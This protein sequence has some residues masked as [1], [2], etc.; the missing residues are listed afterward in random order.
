MPIIGIVGGI[1][2]LTWLFI[3]AGTVDPQS[4]LE[5]TQELG[6]LRQADI[7]LNSVV[8]AS[9]YGLIPD[10]DPLVTQLDAIDRSIG[11]ILHP[12][13]F[14]PAGYRDQVALRARELKGLYRRKADMIDRFKRENSVLRNSLDYFP[15]IADTYLSNHQLPK[16]QDVDH[17]IHRLLAYIRNSDPGLLQQLNQTQKELAAW[18]P[19]APNSAVLQNLLLHSQIIL[20]RYPLVDEVTRDILKLPTIKGQETL[21]RI[22]ATGHAEAQTAAGHFRTVLYIFA[23]FLVGYL[24]LLFFRLESARRAL[25]GIRTDLEQQL[26]AQKRVED[27]LR[28]YATVFTNAAEGMV[29]TDD[30]NRIV[31]VNPAFCAIT[32]FQLEEV[33]GKTPALLRSGRHKEDFYQQ[34]WE[35]LRTTN[36]WR[37]EIWNRR[38]TGELFPEWLSI[39]AV[40]DDTGSPRN[41]LAIFSDITEHKEAEAKIHHLA[42]HDALTG[43]PNRMLLEDRLDQAILQVKRGHRRTAVMYLDLDRFKNINDSLGHDIGDNLLIQVASRCSKTLRETDTICRQ[44]GDEFVI[45]LPDLE[46]EQDAAHIARKLVR[47]FDH[48]FPL[49]GHE[50]RVTAS[51]GIAIYPRDG[52][53]TSELLRNADTAM[54]RAKAEG[55][56]GFC[57]YS[58]DMNAVS[59]SDLLLESQLRRAIDRDELL[60]EFQPKIHAATGAPAGLEAL[61]RW[62]HPDQGLIP[63]SRFIPVAEESGLIGSIGEWVLHTACGQIRRWR[64]AGLPVVPVSVNISAYQ[65]AH[66][67]I[68]EIVRVALTNAG[69]APSLLELELTESLLMHDAAR[70]STILEEFRN[71][72]IGLAIDDFGTGYS[73]LSYLRQFP[74]HTLKIDQSFVADIGKTTATGKIAGAIIALAHS[75]DLQVV[76]EGVETAAQ[77]HYLV[78]HG[79]DQLQGYLLSRPMSH[80][81][82]TA[83]LAATAQVSLAKTDSANCTQ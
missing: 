44:G 37:G 67:D 1:L 51:I 34:L 33:K 9:R 49:G 42:Y 6:R 47:A 69:I 70:A 16:H 23:L 28:L 46:T 29:I 60:L 2:L 77:Q 32:G 38:K 15:S 58:S 79:C 18:A 10:F 52:N 74:V 35:Q 17:F 8:L 3:R 50:L 11:S 19:H 4:H 80:Q 27:T 30:H 73:S 71:M 40:P 13:G 65:F 54:Y 53:S 36:Q 24:G 5:Y 63:P 26:A 81:R 41:Y 14:L 64:D 21:A 25:A 45:V 7:E 48:P 56:N 55:R 43:L 78:S 82:T 39:T 22:Y 75:L 20:E 31:A 12:P 57:F 61:L 59:L 83:W 68:I 76:A 72:G 62:Q 66:Q